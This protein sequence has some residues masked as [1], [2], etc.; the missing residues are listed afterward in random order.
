MGN[1]RKIAQ[2][3]KIRFGNYMLPE[4]GGD[5]SY[6]QAR[7]FDESSIL[8]EE[9]REFI[10]MKEKLQTYLLHD[11]DI[12]FTGKGFRNFAWVYKKEIGP[13][14][15]S[16]IFFILH[17]DLQKVIPDYLA[18]VLNSEKYQSFFQTLGA[19]SS[20][21]SIRKNELEAVEIPVPSITEQKKVVQVAQLH[22]KSLALTNEILEQ[23]NKLYQTIL[24]K[25]IFS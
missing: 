15:A 10:K 13:A 11:G 21:P 20:I 24:H 5:V 3:A 12:L 16:S 7:Q 2:I 19:G 17:P 18:A 22:Q 25:I 4:E 8:Q 6:L 1:R 23:K 9:G 14:I